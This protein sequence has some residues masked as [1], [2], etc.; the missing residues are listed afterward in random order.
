MLNVMH[1]NKKKFVKALFGFF[2]VIKTPLRYLKHGNWGHSATSMVNTTPKRSTQNLEV[3][4][5]TYMCLQ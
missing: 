1:I 2:L 5:T 3:T 4:S